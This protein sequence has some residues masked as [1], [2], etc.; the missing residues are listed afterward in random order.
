MGER[1]ARPKKIEASTSRSEEILDQAAK[2]M[3]DRGVISPRMQDIAA[4]IGIAYTAFYHYFSNRDHL[5]EQMYLRTLRLREV[6]ITS[7]Q[8]ESGLDR[9][10]DFIR[11][12]LTRNIGTKVTLAGVAALADEY[13]KNVKHVRDQVEQGIELLI[14]EGISDGTIRGD[15]SVPILA[16]GIHAIL[17]RFT[18][19]D[20]LSP[21]YRRDMNLVADLILDQLRGG[22]LADR[23]RDISPSYVL[24]ESPQLVG[25]PR[26][27]DDEMDRYQDILRTATRH[28]NDHGSNASIPHIANDLGVTKTVIYQYAEDKQDLLYQCYMRGVQVLEMSHRIAN[29]LGRDPLDAL[30]IHRWNLYRFH[31]G[32]A[33]PFTLINALEYLG[34]HQ[35][36]RVNVRNRAVR[37]LSE[38]RLAEGIAAGQFRRDLHPEISQV[39]F[40]SVFYSLPSWDYLGA[41]LDADTVAEETC[42]LQLRGISPLH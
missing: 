35:Q 22:I 12:D 21:A 3:Q 4:E 2:V 19:V 6:N 29:D 41:G 13:H 26:G 7:A 23:S 5:L 20:F 39:L 8:G 27:V 18:R 42:A 24:Q 15:L 34:P 33:G 9:L 36:R 40:G 14:E 28:F 10:L 1:M 32:S 38:R 37:K 11:S 25:P 17:N 31:A 30:L 16:K